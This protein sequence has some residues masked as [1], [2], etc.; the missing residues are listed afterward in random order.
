MQTG[1]GLWHK[2]RARPTSRGWWVVAVAAMILFAGT[3]PGLARWGKDWRDVQRVAGYDTLIVE[4]AAAAGLEP[5]LVRAV[6]RAESSGNAEAKSARGAYGL[7]QVTRITEK[8]VLQRNPEMTKGDLYDPRY[9]LEI[10]TTYLG[11]LLG[12]FDG[13]LM[14]AL[15]AYHMGPTAVRRVQRKHPGITP[16]RLLAEHAGPKTRAYVRKVLGEH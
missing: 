4:Y 10:G 7:M 14:L 5:G 9:N 11:Y 16:E 15:T 6:V 2:A 12:R 13:D 8:D 3:G 1:L